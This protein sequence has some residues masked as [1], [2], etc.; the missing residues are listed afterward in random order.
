MNEMQVFKNDMFEVSIQLEDG[1]VLFDAENVASCLGFTES[2]NKKDYV[3]WRRVNQYIKPFG[4]SAENT[5]FQDVGKGDF[6]PEALVYKLAFKASNE[7]AEKFQDWLAIEVLPSIR[8]HGAY[9][10]PQK[11]EE[12]LLN[13]DILIK[14]ATNLKME[15]EKRIL[16]EKQLERD[17]PKVLFAEAWE[18]SETSILVGEMA[19]LLAKNGI[20][21]MG[22]NRF[23]K[24]LRSKGFLHKNGE[25]YNLP[26]QRAIELEIIEVKTTTIINPDGSTRVTKTPK[27]T[28]KGQ[29]Y[30]IGKFKEKEI[31]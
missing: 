15:Q 5:N 18:V 21:D 6:I 22:Q 1:E 2:K 10:T 11:L 27:V 19:K 8:K 30:F 25:Q 4:T 7:V 3:M 14:L 20:E 13:P 26:S 12:V 9:M 28:V 16:A 31:A 24:W 17:K 29:I 23:F